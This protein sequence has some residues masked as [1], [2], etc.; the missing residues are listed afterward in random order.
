VVR[1]A[2][3]GRK[4]FP[5]EDM[6]A[7]LIFLEPFWE[8]KS[9][10][11]WSGRVAGWELYVPIY[12]SRNAS[13]SS[14]LFRPLTLMHREISTSL[15]F[16]KPVDS[17]DLL[18][19]VDSQAI[20]FTTIQKLLKI[21][22]MPKGKE[23][24]L[25]IFYDL[26]P[27]HLHPL[28]SILPNATYILFTASYTNL[29]D[30]S[31]AMGELITKYDIQQAVS[32][33]HLMQVSTETRHNII[34]DKETKKVSQ[35]RLYSWEI[36]ERHIDALAND[37]VVHFE[38]RV[39]KQDGKGLIVVPN[40]R[41]VISLYE[42]I[43]KI[44]PEWHSENDNA[45]FVKGILLSGLL[46]PPEF[47][48]YSKNQTQL[49]HLADRFKTKGS[50]FKLAI[51]S[52]LWLTGLDIPSLHTVYLCRPM[53]KHQLIQLFA[54][55]ARPDEG[56]KDALLVDYTKSAILAKLPGNLP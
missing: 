49:L 1:P 19:A 55:L 39:H 33:G 9:R 7:K 41:T 45:G 42:A 12:F 22:P 52:G 32:D 28:F 21:T 43:I 53:Q 50:S 35:S 27:G 8:E 3:L 13:F 29:L 23:N 48:Q 25:V 38:I 40:R 17:T 54:R 46:D 37:I 56:K 51:T 16:Q 24:V 15:S 44:R 34:P 18:K 31:E 10:S 36:L 5:P 6:A 30:Y 11:F 4:V 47:F 14:Y 2:Y 20:I 26:S